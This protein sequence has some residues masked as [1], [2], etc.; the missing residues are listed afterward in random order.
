MVANMTFAQLQSSVVT[1]LVAALSVWGCVWL[2]ACDREQPTNKLRE[3]EMGGRTMGTSFQI[4]LLGPPEL[5]LISMEKSVLEQLARLNKIFSTYDPTSELSELNKM[6]TTEKIPISRELADTLAIAKGISAASNGGLD[7]TLGPVVELWGFGATEA[8]PFFA[9]EEQLPLLMP[10]VGEDLYLIDQKNRTVSKN[11][12]EVS[13]DLSALAK[14]Y[15]VDVVYEWLKAQGIQNLLVEIGGEIKAGGHKLNGGS[16]SAGL[17]VP[18][19]DK[20]QVGWMVALNNVAVASSGDYRHFF[21]HEGVRYSHLLDPR[22]GRPLTYKNMNVSVVHRE[23]IM[24]DAW[25]T[26][27][28]VL[29]PETGLPIAEKHNIAVQYAIEN[30]I[31]R[32]SAFRRLDVR[33]F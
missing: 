26:A 18:L 21:E 14:G 29:G 1:P 27:L 31:I 17:E 6:L 23:A 4:R 19:A 13:F 32:S 5:D 3:F 20:R 9:I 10:Y 15:T 25:A 7:I 12:P 2:T 16:W 28:S 33:K 30:K 11:K 22:T 8:K 24:A